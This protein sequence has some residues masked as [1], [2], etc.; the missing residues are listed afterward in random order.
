MGEPVIP[1]Y[2]PLPET[3][4]RTAAPRRPPP[5]EGAKKG[6]RSPWSGRRL[7][8]WNVAVR[9]RI[10]PAHLFFLCLQLRSYVE[11]GFPITEAWRLAA[12]STNHLPLRSVCRAVHRDLVAGQPLGKALEKHEGKVPRFFI[13]MLASAERSGSHVSVL[14]MLGQHYS[15]LRAL[16]GEIVKAAFYPIA[17]LLLGLFVFSVTTFIL[18]GISEH[19]GE[20]GLPED[21]TRTFLSILWSFFWRALVAAILAYAL[22]TVMQRVRALRVPV[23]YLGLY[24]PFV[25]SVIRRY[26]VAN[27]CRMYAMLQA[28]GMHPASVYRDAAAS[29]GSVPLERRLLRWEKF[30]DDGE[31]VTEAL[32]RAG[33]LPFEVLAVIEVTEYAASSDVVLPRVADLITLEVRHE[34]KSIAQTLVPLAPFLIALAFFG[35]GLIAQIPLIGPFLAGQFIYVALF[36]LFFLVFLI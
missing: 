2:D 25:G 3:L 17:V 19:Q 15:W 22:T 12:E 36:V 11:A 7:G 24:T 28:A 18:Q 6:R 16:K 10:G 13:K 5:P 35:V 23:D 27:F 32:R 1:K 20:L 31:P 26:C 29:M 4:R 33:V 34:M 21:A 8:W 14:D 9:Y 30:V